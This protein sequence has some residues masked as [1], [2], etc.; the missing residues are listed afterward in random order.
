M[1]V[2]ALLLA[3]AAAALLF[4]I[5]FPPGSPTTTWALLP[6]GRAAGSPLVV[7]YENARHPNA[8]RLESALRARGYDLVF[9]G[10][11]DRWGGFGTKVL[12]VARFLKTAKIPDS[13]LVFVVDARDVVPNASPEEAAAAFGRYFPRDAMVT[14]A[15]RACCVP[16]TSKA[17]REWMDVRNPKEDFRFLNAGLIAGR[18]GTLRSVYPF[19]V[20]R[21]NQDDQAQLIEYWH[22]NPEGIVLDTQQRLFSNANKWDWNMVTGCPYVRGGDGAKPAFIQTQGGYWECYDKLFGGGDW[23]VPPKAEP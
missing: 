7:A 8:V 5:G 4:L 20:T 22:R 1:Q 19:G 15:E 3:I 11:N 18:A 23:R 13:R 2:V 14:G 10:D 12:A 21:E 6:R 17:L 9:L 16:A